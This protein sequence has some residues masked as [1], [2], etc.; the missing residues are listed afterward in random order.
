[1]PWLTSGDIKLTTLESGNLENQ[2]VTIVVMQTVLVG[3]KVDGLLF[4]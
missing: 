2:Q 1:M 3:R 4:S